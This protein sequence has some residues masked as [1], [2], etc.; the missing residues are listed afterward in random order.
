MLQPLFLCCTYFEMHKNI[1]Y[2]VLYTLLILYTECR[3]E[4]KQGPWE[5]G[6]IESFNARHSR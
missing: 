3:K 5:N 2:L 6:Y 1:S 4:K